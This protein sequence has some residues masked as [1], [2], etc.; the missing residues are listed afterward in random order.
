[1]FY[2]V[3]TPIGNSE[4]ITLRAVKTLTSSAIVLCEDTRS[5]MN[6]YKK[7]QELFHI[8]PKSSQKFIAFHK[9]NEFHMTTQI[10]SWI[11]EGK[12]ISL[13]SESGMPVVSD[14]G[15]ILIQQMIKKNLPYTVIP[16]PTAF[17]NALVLSGFG[18]E[19]VLFLG[20][21]PKKKSH[22]LRLLNQLK[23]ISESIQE[24]TILTY[25]SPHRINATLELFDSIFPNM[26]MCMC[27]E[28]TKKFEEVI[29]G[30]P[31]ELKDISYK[32]ELTLVAKL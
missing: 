26:I 17:V 21:L 12:D 24:L 10:I 3:A 27:R 2:I 32:G 5:F 6:L 19:K 29:R 25:E 28:M 30:K 4:D 14:P 15:N 16:G 8:S 31:H 9:D 23:Q 20:F 18:T 13:V 11:Q 1:M 7:T 22:V